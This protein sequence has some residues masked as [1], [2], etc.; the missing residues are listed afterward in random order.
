M[1]CCASTG[2]LESCWI[3]WSAPRSVT[4]IALFSD[5]LHADSRARPSER[6]SAPSEC[7]CSGY[8]EVRTPGRPESRTMAILWIS[9]GTLRPPGIQEGECMRTPCPCFARSDEGSGVPVD[10]RAISQADTSRP[11]CEDGAHRS[12]ELPREMVTTLKSG[13]SWAGIIATH[14]SP[15]QRRNFD[16]FS[17]RSRR[18]VNDSC[19]RGTGRRLLGGS[20]NPPRKIGWC[21]RLAH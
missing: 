1:K 13:S 2:R 9:R 18:D 10:R 20:G 16:L 15:T 17:A 3:H 6:G 7:R 19:G 14:G 21:A 4:I 11:D 12:G 8:R 5:P